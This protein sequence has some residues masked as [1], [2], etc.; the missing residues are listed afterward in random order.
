MPFVS[1]LVFT[2]DHPERQKNGVFLFTS[3][4]AHCWVYGFTNEANYMYS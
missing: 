1:L 4:N 2:S 3:L